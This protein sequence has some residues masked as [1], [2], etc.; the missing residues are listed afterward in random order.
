MEDYQLFIIAERKN[1]I[2]K[3]NIKM[4]E[5][6]EKIKELKDTYNDDINK[7]ALKYDR[8]KEEL[9]ELEEEYNKLS[10]DKILYHK[11]ECIQLL[12]EAIAK[13]E[14]SIRFTDCLRECYSG[15]EN[16]TLFLN[17]YK[18]YSK[19]QKQITME[20][21]EKDIKRTVLIYEYIKQYL[22]FRKNK[23]EI[24]NSPNIIAELLFKYEFEKRD[25]INTIENLK[26]QLMERQE[27]IKSFPNKRE[28]LTNK[29]KEFLTEIKSLVISDIYVK[30]N[31]KIHEYS[32]LE[33]E[34][35]NY[36]V[37]IENINSMNKNHIISK[38]Y[39]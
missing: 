17:A 24:S 18:K 39:V 7:I 32:E 3:N 30:Y 8:V 2:E 31:E 11:S 21:R 23:K 4:N 33:K 25:L 37:Q 28:T 6:K 19:Y 1:R 15:K 29:L 10:D 26:F 27:F 12:S 13:K 9:N 34:N 16:I 5:L 38:K 20:E 14:K 22:I 35:I 36:Q